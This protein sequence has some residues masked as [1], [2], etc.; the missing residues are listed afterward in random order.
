[1]KRQY[2]HIRILLLYAGILSFCIGCGKREVCDFSHP[3]SGNVHFLFDWQHLFGDTDMPQKMTMHFYSATGDTLISHILPNEMGSLT[4]PAD[5]YQILIYNEDQTSYSI[6]ELE[7]LHTAAVDHPIQ[8]DG[9]VASAEP[10][11]ACVIES[12]SV[13]PDEQIRHTFLPERYSQRISFLIQVNGLFNPLACSATLSGLAGSVLM[14]TRESVPTIQSVT[15][16]FLLSISGSRVSGSLYSLRPV[17]ATT[18]VTGNLL[19][20]DFTMASGLQ[21]SVNADITGALAQMINGDIEI[22]LLIDGDEIS[23]I[24]ATVT[25]WVTGNDVTVVIP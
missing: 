8:S 21:H 24:K 16:S 5:T 17:A 12:F 23:G 2:F 7:Y 19:T 25:A 15:A 14:A 18:Q 3:H 22:S 20:L 6:R 9:M 10:F 13:E 1:M 4:L 11:Y